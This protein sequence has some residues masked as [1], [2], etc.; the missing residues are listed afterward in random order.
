MSDDFLKDLLSAD[1]A[2]A[3]VPAVDY[4]FT[5][6]VMQTIERRRFYENA[7]VLVVVGVAVTVLLGLVMPFITPALVALSADILP[8]AIVLVSLA[9]VAFGYINLR[10]ALRT[11]GLN[12]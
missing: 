12:L 7:A 8:A 4:T 6:S 9:A 5:I 11:F 10:P 1:P 2:P 3:S